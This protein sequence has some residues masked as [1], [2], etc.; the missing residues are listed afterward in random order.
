MDKYI[1]TNKTSLSSELCNDIIQLF[2]IENKKYEGV[3]A[4]GLNKNIKNTM[5]FVIPKDNNKWYK[6]YNFLSKEL[7]I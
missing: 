2:E 1:Y 6:I 3:T 7:Q 4:A 5:D